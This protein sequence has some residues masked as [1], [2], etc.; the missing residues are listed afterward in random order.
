MLQRERIH[1]VGAIETIDVGGDHRVERNTA[2]LHTIM[3][4]EQGI[5]LNV[6]PDLLYLLIFKNGTKHIEHFPEFKTHSECILGCSRLGEE[7]CRIRIGAKLRKANRNIERLEW[8]H[9]ERHPNDL[10]SI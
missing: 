5:I 2:D 4:Q 1:R 9:R 3:S 10:G 8:A 7:R 6:L